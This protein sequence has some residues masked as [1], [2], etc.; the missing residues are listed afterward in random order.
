MNDI[1]QNM[2]VPVCESWPHFDF[3]KDPG[4]ACPA[5]SAGSLMVLPSFTVRREAPWVLFI[6]KALPCNSLD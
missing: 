6:F 4:G 2:Q 1:L 3:F 5:C